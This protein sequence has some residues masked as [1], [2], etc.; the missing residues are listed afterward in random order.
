MQKNKEKIIDHRKAYQE[1]F[2]VHGLSKI[3]TGKSQIPW[4]ALVIFSF[5][6]AIYLTHQHWREFLNREVH[7]ERT[8]RVVEKKLFFPP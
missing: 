4:A 7:I 8:T 1:N 3:L 2:T 5:I 6:G